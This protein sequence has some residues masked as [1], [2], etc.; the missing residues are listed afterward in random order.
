MR[1]SMPNTISDTLVLP[2]LWRI[3]GF[4]SSIVGFICYALSSSFKQLVGE[5]NPWKIV[6]Y[7]LVILDGMWTL[8][9]SLDI[10]TKVVVDQVV[11][12]QMT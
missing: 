1:L 11:M 5:W 10:M 12:R 7:C 8:R 3:V 6:I 9:I 2:L 4:V